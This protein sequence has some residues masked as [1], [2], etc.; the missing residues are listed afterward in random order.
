[1]SHLT[2]SCIGHLARFYE[3]YHGLGNNWQCI[4]GESTW[5]WHLYHLFRAIFT[6]YEPRQEVRNFLVLKLD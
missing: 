6:A 3:I 1:M 5:L 4:H 2:N